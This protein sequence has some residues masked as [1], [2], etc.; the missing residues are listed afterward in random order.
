MVTVLYCHVQNSITFTVQTRRH[1]SHGNS[2]VLVTPNSLSLLIDFHSLF[3][4]TNGSWSQFIHDSNS[5]MIKIQSQFL[6]SQGHINSQ[7][8][9]CHGHSSVM[10][11]VQSWSIH[12]QALLSRQSWSL[13]NYDHILYFLTS[14][15]YVKFVTYSIT[16]RQ[17]A[18]PSTPSLKHPCLQT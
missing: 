8:L 1:F 4:F 15:L 16:E 6:F 18:P 5:V 9:H 13:V 7:T 10:V 12:L 2:S 3:T 17:N 14:Y 11:L